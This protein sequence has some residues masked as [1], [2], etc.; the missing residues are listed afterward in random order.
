[1]QCSVFGLGASMCRLLVG[2]LP[3]RVSW[4]VIGAFE[5]AASLLCALTPCSRPRARDSS[6]FSSLL[7]SVSFGSVSGGQIVAFDVDSLIGRSR[8]EVKIAVSPAA[9]RKP[10]RMWGW[11]GVGHGPELDDDGVP[12]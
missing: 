6:T 1:M 3:W 9:L 10:S 11:K 4:V 2:V 7:F 8:Y 12:G 5:A